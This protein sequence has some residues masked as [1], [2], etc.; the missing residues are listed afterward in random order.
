MS[1]NLSIVYVLNSFTSK[2]K[3]IMI[4][5]R[6]LVLT[7]MTY[8]ILIKSTHLSGRLNIIPDL[9]SRGQVHLALEKAPYL[10]ELP[11]SIPPELKINKLLGI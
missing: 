9:L 5:L 2:D 7:C 8:N 1:D 11:T 10:D 4:L 6:Q 3:Y